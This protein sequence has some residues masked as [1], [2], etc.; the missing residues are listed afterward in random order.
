MGKETYQFQELESLTLIVGVLFGA[1][2]QIVLCWVKLKA[3]VVQS[4]II[5]GKPAQ[6]N[7]VF[8]CQAA[9]QTTGPLNTLPVLAG[10]V[11]HGDSAIL[12]D[13]KSISLLSLPGI[14]CHEVK[15]SVL[16][17]SLGIIK[18]LCSPFNQILLLC[19]HT[20]AARHSTWENLHSVMA[21]SAALTSGWV[22]CSHIFTN[23][24]SPPSHSQN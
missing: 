17:K 7:K 22:L 24:S 11:Y 8:Y 19:W 12:N 16:R 13:S 10:Q 1:W 18:V 5:K 21:S 3:E 23:T 14:G 9:N 4:I 6:I 2:T 20:R 15:T